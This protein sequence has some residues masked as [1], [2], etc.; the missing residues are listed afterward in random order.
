MPPVVCL[1]FFDVHKGC[2]INVF[3]LYIVNCLLWNDMSKHVALIMRPT[4]IEFVVCDG[5]Y[6][7]CENC[8]QNLAW[9]LFLAVSAPPSWHFGRQFLIRNHGWQLCFL[10]V[11][12]RTNRNHYRER[13]I[14]GTPAGNVPART[15]P[16]VMRRK[17]QCTAVSPAWQ[18]WLLLQVTLTA[19][20]LICVARNWLIMCA[21]VCVQFGNW[22]SLSWGE[23]GGGGGRILGLEKQL[24]LT[25]PSSDLSLLL[26]PSLSG[27]LCCLF[28]SFVSLFVLDIFSLLFPV[29]FVS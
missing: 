3:N 4:V 23:R 18:F 7:T 28:L 8:E 24:H 6:G 27:F 5:T 17:Q 10:T 12:W 29:I 20:C 14:M 15:Q 2:L 22:E 16:D 13:C 19:A 11:A 21:C 9:L 1:A 25:L 26:P